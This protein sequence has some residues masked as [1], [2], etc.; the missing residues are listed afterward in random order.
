MKKLLSIILCILITAAQCT[1]FAAE[2]E[3]QPASVKKSYLEAMEF[4]SDLGLLDKNT[5][6]TDLATRGALAQMAAKA[7]GS[8]EQSAVDTDFDDVKAD[9]VRSGYILYAAQNGLMKGYSDGVFEPNDGVSGEQLVT[10]LVRMTGYNEM[11]DKMGGDAAAYT[12][13]ALKAGLLKYVT[14]ADSTAAT[15]GEVAY[16]VRNALDIDIMLAESINGTDMTYEIQEGK[17]LLSNALGLNEVY[18]RVTANYYTGLS[19][20]S[21]LEKGWIELARENYRST[22]DNI[23]EYLGWYVTAYTDSDG[24]IRAVKRDSVQNDDITI[25]SA[26]ILSVANGEIKYG[27]DG[28]TQ[29]ATYLK[30]GYL[31]YNGEAKLSWGET[32]LK[33]AKNALLRLIDTD[34]DGVYDVIF[35]NRYADMIVRGV[36]AADDMIYFKSGSARLSVNLH[37]DT[38]VKYKIT[39]EN[40]EELAVAEIP[41]GSLLSLAASNSDKVML[42]TVSK[43]SFTGKCTAIDDETVTIDE[44]EYVLGEDL[45]GTGK[46]K[47]NSEG[48]F[49]LNFMGK[50]A[51]FDSDPEQNYAYLRA[52]GMKSEFR[53]GMEFELFTADGEFKIFTLAD[54]VKVNGAQTAVKATTLSGS[55][56]LFESGNTKNQLITYTLNSE[57]KINAFCTADDGSAMTYHQKKDIFTR[58]AVLD[59]EKDTQTRYIGATW[60]MFAGRYLV[61]DTTKIF[62]VPS[63][64]DEDKK[65][66]VSGA[67]SLVNEKFY[68]HVEIFD[69]DENNIVKAIVLSADGTTSIDQ[70]AP[71]GVVKKIKTVC[72]ADGINY[73]AAVLSVGG[74]DITV[75]SDSSETDVR[76]DEAF[77]DTAGD[78]D[79]TVVSSAVQPISLGNVDIGDVICYNAD[80]D[81]TIKDAEILLRAETPVEKESWPGDSDNPTKNYFYRM[82][83]AAYGEVEAV[84]DGGI[85]IT[86]PSSTE[87]GVRYTRVLPFSSGTVTIKCDSSLKGELTDI[88]YSEI[89]EGDKVF[90][91][92]GTSGV[93]LCVVYR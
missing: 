13:A 45:R 83:Y 81:G 51:A 65:F 47:L 70:T 61:S 8:G 69:E 9:D 35:L 89:A 22:K 5:S 3:A 85:R 77:T 16:A 33:N 37:K 56:L 46:I 41:S 84:I 14:L 1:A 87:A 78:D 39:D 25:D 92:A 34:G 49:Y 19:G 63:N 17:T 7:T 44:T 42:F 60:K 88:T 24:V 52:A 82:R 15:I 21:N 43:T 27:G 18:G 26:D 93:K 68:G 75:I 79:Y 71:I 66:S 62:S 67:G 12:R 50:V 74:K 86:V 28:K 90:V 59:G 23:D 40:G 2:G 53:G 55:S 6:A 32:E 91:Y 76:M 72:A 10:V 80:G 54:K 57:G 11:A 64:L 73:N 58:D 31:I 38:K 20:T 29:S 4:L 36:S 30:N 48:V